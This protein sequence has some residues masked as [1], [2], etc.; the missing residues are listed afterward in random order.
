MVHSFDGIKKLSIPIK[1]TETKETETSTQNLL[2]LI[3]SD[4]T[5]QLSGSLA[6][7]KKVVVR[8]P[9]HP[10]GDTK[11]PLESSL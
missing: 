9:L 7:T 10:A 6:S 8:N 3:P 11:N 4:L 2:I 1:M 5:A